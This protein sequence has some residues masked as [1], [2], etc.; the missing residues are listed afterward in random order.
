[1]FFVLFFS[2]EYGQVLLGYIV[3]R[4]YRQSDHVSLIGGTVAC[5]VQL[6]KDDVTSVRGMCW[7]SVSFLS[8]LLLPFNM[9]LHPG[10]L[11]ALLPFFF[12]C[13]KLS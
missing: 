10:L 8:G 6:L 4:M 3:F 7:H 11:S 12:F 2:D 9:A 1:M 13:T 5:W